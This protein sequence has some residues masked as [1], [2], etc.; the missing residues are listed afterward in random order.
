MVCFVV[1]LCFSFEG[2]YLLV[3]RIIHDLSRFH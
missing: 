3:F 2:I 1:V